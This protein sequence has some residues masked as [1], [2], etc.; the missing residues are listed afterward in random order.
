MPPIQT[1]LIIYIYIYIYI[2]IV[3]ER[4][5]YA[6]YNDYIDYIYCTNVRCMPPILIILITHIDQ[7]CAVCI[8]YCTIPHELV[9]WSNTWFLRAIKM[10]SSSQAKKQ[11]ARVA[12]GRYTPCTRIGCTTLDSITHVACSAAGPEA[13][14]A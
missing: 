7:T 3:H 4:V 1:I 8:L 10:V 13:Q 5:L 14:H 11:A 12:S 2:Y 6:S 9:K